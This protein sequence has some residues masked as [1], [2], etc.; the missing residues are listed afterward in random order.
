MQRRAV[1]AA[2]LV[3]ATGCA[4]V[5]SLMEGPLHVKR[6][7]RPSAGE[8]VEAIAQDGAKLRASWLVPDRGFEQCV[9]VLHGIGDSRAASAGF[10][11]VLLRERYAV[12]APDSRAHGE[13]GG[14]LVTYG[15]L[16][17][18]DALAWTEW[19]RAKGCTTIY[20]LGESLGAS[21]L[22][23]AA[24]QSNV[25]RSIVAESPFADLQDAAETRLTRILPLPGFLSARLARFAAADTRI[26]VRLVH[27]MDLTDA[28][29]LRT[30]GQVT[31]PVL[32]IHGLDDDQTPPEHSRR[33]AAA[34]P[35]I[36]SLWLVPGVKH[37]SAYS[38]NP[39]EWQK[40]ILS[41]FASH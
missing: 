24:A 15:L 5:V 23:Q 33:L 38:K 39:V 35:A 1:W 9:L 8:P 14:R 10:A 20:G 25:F 19:M 41:W 7:I 40:R 17:R 34:N 6:R 22:L 16:E 27:G 21:V 11:P 36:T 18:Y 29:P 3:A 4:I 28:S 2:I 37:Y 12:L 31:T 13:S 26:Y 30:M 32:L